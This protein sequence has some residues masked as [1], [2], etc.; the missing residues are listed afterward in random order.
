[1][2]LCYPPGLV[3][4]LDFLVLYQVFQETL[5]IPLIPNKLLPYEYSSQGLLLGNPTQDSY[6][7]K[8]KC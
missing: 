1:M 3:S 5:A 6:I 4:H 2:A 8:S 7:N